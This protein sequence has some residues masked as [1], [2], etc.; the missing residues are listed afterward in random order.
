MPIASDERG[1]RMRIKFERNA[2][3]WRSATCHMPY[4]LPTARNSSEY[5][6]WKIFPTIV[7]LLFCIKIHS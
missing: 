6:F 5:Q 2:S 1:V 3:E 4:V 7:L